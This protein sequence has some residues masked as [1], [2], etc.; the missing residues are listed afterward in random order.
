[1]RFVNPLKKCL[2]VIIGTQGELRSQSL[3]EFTKGF[4]DCIYVNPVL[5]GTSDRTGQVVDDK[6]CEVSIGRF[7]E[8]SEIGCALAH[9][10]ATAIAANTV[11]NLNEVGWVLFAEDDADL[12][13]RTFETI[14]NELN[15]L[16]VSIPA[17][18]TFFS[19]KE[20]GPGKERMKGESCKRVK[21][22]AHWPSGTVCYAI[23]R[24]G[25]SDIAKFSGLPVDHVADWPIYYTRLKLFFS[26]QTRVCE[27]D[28]PSS[29]QNR[30][31]LSA[32]SRIIMH[33]RQLFYLR[34]L[35]RINEVSIWKVIN[36]LMIT[37]IT[38]DFSDQIRSF[39]LK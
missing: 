22:T 7:M 39:Q 2:V 23:N 24:S 34:K 9:K 3:N 15:G 8:N 27:V 5:I 14:Q 38:R 10:K 19:P 26:L 36:H 31:N 20:C 12:N 29:I 13:Q 33:L 28:A 18:I 30:S 16:N 6:L 17:L 32:L 25:L 11:S 37:P 21:S 4:G 1:M 35:S